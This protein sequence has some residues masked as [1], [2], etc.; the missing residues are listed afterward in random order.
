MWEDLEKE[1]RV[2]GG[3]GC[4][5]G[6]KEWEGKKWVG[7]ACVGEAGVCLGGNRRWNP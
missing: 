1:R 2:N 3:D 5:W 7:S 6:R 4:S